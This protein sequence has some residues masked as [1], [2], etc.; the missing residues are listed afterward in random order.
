MIAAVAAIIFGLLTVFSGGNAVPFVL[1]F[2]FVAGFLY[3]AAGVGLFLRRKW[4][5]WLSAAIALATTVVFAA[6]ALVVIGGT[7]YETRTIF[8]MTLRTGIWAVIA[9]IAYRK[10]KL[11]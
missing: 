5:F 4:S 9:V 7:A 1:W 3:V 11:D 8:A 6:F 10:I 2:N